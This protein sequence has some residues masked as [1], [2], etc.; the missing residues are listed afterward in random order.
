MSTQPSAPPAPDASRFTTT[1][2]LVH[3]P[4]GAPFSPIPQVFAVQVLHM[5]DS[6]Q[7]WAGLPA[8]GQ[9]E[10]VASLLARKQTVAE[11]DT[12]SSQCL[13][14]KT[15]AANVDEEEDEELKA[16][17]KA[18]GRDV[19]EGNNFSASGNVDGGE[20]YKRLPAGAV[21][22]EWAIAMA[23]APTPSSAPSQA[24]GSSLFRT[25]ADL[26]LPMALR[27]ARKLQIRQIHL[28]IDVPAEVIHAAST[29][30]PTSSASKTLVMLEKGITD[31]LKVFVR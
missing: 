30:P 17:L 27:I 12:Q 20:D 5:Q 11:S 18:A 13:Q 29:A 19:P 31:I 15:D 21:A 25:S 16:A 2:H 22:S 8:S 26:A 10:E 14:L 6:F 1:S 3:I 23:S 28:S 4:S 7:V 9:D 24:Q